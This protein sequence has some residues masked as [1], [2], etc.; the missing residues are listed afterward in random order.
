MVA[1]LK[2]CG[3]NMTIA[4]WRQIEKNVR[5]SLFFANYVYFCVSLLYQILYVSC[6]L[7]DRLPGHGSIR[8]QIA[9]RYKR[10]VKGARSIVLAK[11]NLR[12]AE[13]NWD[14][15][16]VSTHIGESWRNILIRSL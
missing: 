8:A 7:I 9:L 12:F 16:D 3:I 5:K 6:L 4:I 13:K 14:H 11:L 15:G 1:A 2:I 10:P